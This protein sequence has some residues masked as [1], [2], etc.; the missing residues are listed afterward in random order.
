MKKR[1][2]IFSH[3]RKLNKL[4]PYEMQTILG[5]SRQRYSAMEKS[6]SGRFEVTLLVRLQRHFFNRPGP[7]A[8]YD[9]LN[10]YELL[11]EF[12]GK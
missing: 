4:E 10:F 5:I 6:I 2:N 9:K 12:Y 8:S 11:E 1:K 7:A 3:I